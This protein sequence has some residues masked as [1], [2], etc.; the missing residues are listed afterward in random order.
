[1]NLIIKKYE[2]NMIKIWDNFV[3]NLSINGTIYHTQL[4]LSYHNNKFEDSS[5]LIYEKNKL[6]AVFPCCKDGINYYSHKGSTCGGIVILEKYYK[7]NKLIKIMEKIYDYYNSNL[8]IKLS[9]DIYFRK[10]F[11]NDL[12]NFVLSIKCKKYNDLSLYFNINKEDIL[13]IFPKNDNKRLLKKFIKN[14]DEI[15]FEITQNENEYIQYYKLLRKNLL[16]KNNVKPLHSL[17]EFL[18]LKKKINNKQFL[19]ISKNK[20]N[21]ILSGAYVFQINDYTLYTVYLMTNY[22]KENSQIFY[23]IYYLLLLCQQKNIN[24]LSLGACTK[25]GGREILNS[26]YNFK[27]SCGCFPT[28]KY[29]F[30]FKNKVEINTDRTVLKTMEIEEQYLICNLWKD[31]EY[32]RKMFFFKDNIFNY[33]NQLNWYK[34]VLKSNDMEILSIFHKKEKIFIGYCGIKNINKNDCELFIVILDKKYYNLGLGKETFNE[35]INYTRNK[36]RNIKIYLNVKKNNENAIKLYEKLKFKCK[37]KTGNVYK[38]FLLV[39]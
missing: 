17:E 35:L 13:D 34:N 19:F 1:M 9:E 20:N 37:N 30:E 10:K 14:N 5:I 29:N 15:K 32:A 4:F 22:E 23:L 11:S 24:I 21:E 27:T 16:E 7:L 39:N 3:N 31:N 18:D 33:E 28:L 38:M 6:I 2:N 36:Y 25:N 26:N 12:L 8:Y